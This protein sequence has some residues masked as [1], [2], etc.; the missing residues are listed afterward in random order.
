MIPKHKFV[1][2]NK[3]AINLLGNANKKN[4]IKLI[5]IFNKKNASIN[6]SFGEYLIKSL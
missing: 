5:I 2:V 6:A 3:F 4:Y 1:N